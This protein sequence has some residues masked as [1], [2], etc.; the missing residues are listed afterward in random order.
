[1]RPSARR[2]PPSI[3]STS[4]PVRGAPVSVLAKTLRGMPN[5]TS[6]SHDRIGFDDGQQPV[7]PVVQDAL[8]RHDHR[9]AGVLEFPGLHLP[10]ELRELAGVHAT[11]AR[12]EGESL[13]RERLVE[14][15]GLGAVEVLDAPSELLRLHPLRVRVAGAPAPQRRPPCRA[16]LVVVE[17]MP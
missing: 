11:V 17:P 3:V 7:L 2:Q 9:L 6:M 10:D 13:L 1:M 8:L 12:V 4:P 16:R 15:Q 5:L 14:H